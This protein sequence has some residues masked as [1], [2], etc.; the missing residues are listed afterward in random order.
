[1]APCGT[2]VRCRAGP[3]WPC[4]AT[5]RAPPPSV[6]TQHQPYSQ[7][8]PRQQLLH[9]QASTCPAALSLKCPLLDSSAAVLPADASRSQRRA[10]TELAW[11]TERQA[12]RHGSASHATTV[13]P[14]PDEG[15]GGAAADALSKLIFCMQ[16]QLL[17][18]PDAHLAMMPMWRP[19]CTSVSAPI[20][21]LGT[22]R[23]TFTCKAFVGASKYE[24]KI[25]ASVCL[26]RGA[27]RVVK[28]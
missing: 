21:Q 24:I 5:G 6:R 7:A 25:A 18:D 12:E 16:L 20:K 26:S 3:G 10:K 23:T 17:R 28:W 19:R 14:A 13:S 2:P 8:G 22:L 4:G 9:S 15:G 27:Y 1:M 11:G